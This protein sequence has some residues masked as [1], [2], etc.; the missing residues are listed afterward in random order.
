MSLI[1]RSNDPQTVTLTARAAL[2]I[3]ATMLVLFYVGSIASQ[4]LQPSGTIPRIQETMYELDSA[5]AAYSDLRAAEIAFVN[6]GRPDDLTRFKQ[7][8]ARMKVHLD[9]VFKLINGGP[10]IDELRKLERKVD[11]RIELSEEV[12]EKR[13]KKG[14]NASSWPLAGSQSSRV[15]SAEID[16]RFTRVRTSLKDMLFATNEKIGNANLATLGGIWTLMMFAILM[17]VS[18]LILLD[19]YVIDRQRSE[20]E[21]AEREARIRAIVDTAPDGIL[22][23]SEDGTIESA[24]G[25][26][27]R[28]F[29]Y[30]SEELVGE[31]AQ[32]IIDDFGAAD[33]STSGEMK[34]GGRKIVGHALETL[35]RREDGSTFPIEVTL[36]ILHLS[37][38]KVLTAIVRDITLRKEAER[39]V[40]EFYSTVSHEL[41]TPL[42]SI[43][44][45]LGLMTSGAVGDLSEKGS[46][47]VRIAG[48]ECDRLIRLINDILDFRRI[49]AGKLVLKPQ[50]VSAEALIH[51]TFEAIKGL[52]EEQDIKLEREIKTDDFVHCDPDRIVQV[53]TNLISNAVKF[54]DRGGQVGV[55][56]ERTDRDGFRFSVTDRGP[57]I[58]Q[59]QI[60]KLFTRFQ[61]LDSSDTRKK[62]GTGL[63][64]AISK[65]IVNQH[66]GEIG[67]ETSFGRGSTFWFELPERK[68]VRAASEETLELSR[69]RVLLAVDDDA[70]AEPLRAMISALG[71]SALSGATLAQC[72]RLLSKV[73]DACVMDVELADGSG[74]DLLLSGEA[75][76]VKASVPIVLISGWT[77]ETDTVSGPILIDCQTDP[78]ETERLTHLLGL[79]HKEVG[80]RRVLLVE[81]DLARSALIKETLK[82]SGF[83]V[84]E[85]Q[86]AGTAGRSAREFKP[87]LVVI[88]VSISNERCY[89]VLGE[90]R[91][92]NENVLPLVLYTRGALTP[93]AVSKVTLGLTRHVDGPQL[94][95]EEFLYLTSGLLKGILLT[96][97]KASE[98]HSLV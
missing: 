41:R 53:L 46:H 95:K 32:S 89:E 81:G 83:D 91:K 40:S 65:A 30:V 27:G 12:I 23:V 3:F 31:K 97:K 66:G 55:C 8:N 86:E 63:G 69:L 38:R 47:L 87:D 14:G 88:D 25:A 9:R 49:E 56:V 62:G 4:Q 33:K 57:G 79:T 67:V 45:A 29:G 84:F 37:D 2:A 59:D 1:S 82:R 76:L 73:P 60:S 11:E 18:I 13:N 85:Y 44:T 7:S 6:G 15:L 77:S 58:R 39:R 36:S 17:L 21:L 92:Q 52:A 64:L 61:Q 48:S 20:K 19:R 43:R 16:S 5:Y 96:G 94:S 74:L 50:M 78:F 80:S 70:L 54:S 42:T 75:D 35:G 68:K 51:D 90:L 26:L 34:T 98:S 24:N 71:I 22:I 72:E 28:M 93:S 10:P